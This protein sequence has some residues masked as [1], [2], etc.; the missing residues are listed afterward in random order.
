MKLATLRSSSTTRIRIS[1]YRIAAWAA[2]SDPAVR[3]E[4]VAHRPADGFEVP[5][6]RQ[7]IDGAEAAVDRAFDG[8]ADSIAAVLREHGDAA[9]PSGLASR[10]HDRE[11]TVRDSGR[12]G[13]HHAV[14]HFR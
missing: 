14:G 8:F 7:R 4:L 9:L 2:S 3:R 10:R 11:V 13:R 1:R 5:M 12:R 6:L